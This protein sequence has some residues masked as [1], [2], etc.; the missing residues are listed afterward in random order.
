M[1]M[2][3]NVE[4]AWGTLKKL[5]ELYWS[6]GPSGRV[7]KRNTSKNYKLDEQANNNTEYL[8]YDALYKKKV[9]F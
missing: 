1:L 4:S 2:K 6:F 7:L 5:I 9:V 8:K 3:L